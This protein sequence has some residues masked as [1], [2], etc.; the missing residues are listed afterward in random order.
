MQVRIRGRHVET[1]T[2]RGAGTRS[3]RSAVTGRPLAGHVGALEVR[4]AQGRGRVTV[5]QQPTARNGNTAVIEIRDPRSGYGY[6]DF[7]VVW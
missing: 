2:L 3:V 4:Q 1:V 5:I 6:Y 7:D